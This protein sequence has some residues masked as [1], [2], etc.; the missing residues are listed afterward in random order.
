MQE[1]ILTEQQQ[2]DLFQAVGRRIASI[3]AK[4]PGLTV[5]QQIPTISTV[6][7]LGAFVSLKRFGQLRSC[8]G[9]MSD[10][11]PLGEAV[12]GAAIRAAK[13]DPR[14]QPIAAAELPDLEMEVWLLWGMQRVAARGHDRLK[15]VE[16]GRHGVQIAMGGNRGLLLPGVAIE[17]GMDSLTFLEAVCRK[18]GLHSDAW[19]SDHALVHTFEGKAIRGPLTAVEIT[20]QKTMSELGLAI[21]FQRLGPRTPGPTPEETAQ[22]RK[23]CLESFRAMI[24]GRTPANYHPGLF[25]GNVSGVSL[26]FTLMERPP[27]IVSKIS[28][29]PDI[30]LQASLLEL[31]KVI[32]SQIERFG[33]T[34]QELLDITIDLSILWDPQ[35]HGN[36]VQHELE[37]FDTKFRSLMVSSSNGWVVQYRPELNAEQVVNECAD[38]ISLQDRGM[39]EVISFETATTAATYTISSVSRPNR[40]PEI[41]PAAVAGAFYPDNPKKIAAELNRMFQADPSDKK[42]PPPSDYVA[43]MIPHAGWIYSGHLAAQTLAQVRFPKRAMIFAPKHRPGGSDWSVAPNAVWKFPGG[44]LTTDIDLAEQFVKAVDYF[45]FDFIPHAEEHAIEVQ[46]PLIARLAPKTKI[47]GC[48]QSMSSWNMISQAATQF[49]A[50]LTKQQ[51]PPLLIVSSDMN[52]FASEEITRRIDRIA[53]DAI[54][55]LNPEHVLETIQE[56]QI[57]M[58]GVVPLVFVM[59]TLKLLG[60]LNACMSTGYTTSAEQSGDTGRV[61]GYAGMLFR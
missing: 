57:S 6:P 11:I 35:I 30:Q 54:E 34:R 16:V 48:V 61:V 21:R 59:Q 29:R 45:Q 14:F 43:V 3:V 53:L 18:A 20:D 13:D 26:A 56:N 4:T 52:H 47:V 8:M 10:S 7:L 60:R 38:Y 49:A 19:Y 36:V 15:A 40:T 17:Y 51:D 28:V 46:L 24:D 58:C 2:Y 25:D 37:G 22:L 39:G 32:G 44:E 27:I 41:R 42:L 31:L 1:P 33:V 12:D 9:Y 55:T 50:F 5:S 23:V